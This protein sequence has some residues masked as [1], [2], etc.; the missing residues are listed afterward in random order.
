M[1]LRVVPLRAEV[2]RPHP[3]LSESA[4]VHPFGPNGRTKGRTTGAHRVVERASFVFD[5]EALDD[6]LLAVVS[7]AV[8]ISRGLRRLGPHRHTEGDATK[9]IGAA[10]RCAGRSHTRSPARRGGVDHDDHRCGRRVQPLSLL[11]L[12]IWT[13]RAASRGT[14]GR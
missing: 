1:A 2:L 12:D 5:V 14:A 10:C 7:I 13:E 9:G 4:P 11:V 6:E 8:P 3:L